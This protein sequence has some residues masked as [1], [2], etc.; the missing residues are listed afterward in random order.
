LDVTV[1]DY[2]S[3][4]APALHALADNK[5]TNSLTIGMLEIAASAELAVTATLT[6]RRGRGKGRLFVDALAVAAQR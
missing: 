2:Q 1:P 3:L 5:E 4:M 6:T